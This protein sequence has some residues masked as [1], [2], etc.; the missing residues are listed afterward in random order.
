MTIDFEELIR[1]DR[2]DIKDNSIRSYL[3]SLRKMN[4]NQA[5]TDLKFLKNYKKIVEFL[6]KFALSTKRNYISSILVILKG[7]NKKSYDDV[8]EKYKKL[9]SELN[10]EYNKKIDSHEKSH[11]Q[12]ENWMPL[13]ELK[14]GL[15]IFKKEIKERE[16]KDKA[17]PS[18]KDMEIL[19]QYVVVALYTLHAPVRLNYANMKIINSAKDIKP[20]INYLLIT[21][22]NKKQFIFQEYKTSK[23]GGRKDIPVKKELNSV[24]NMWLKYNKSSYLLLDS[25]DEPMNPN[26]L[27]KYITKSF[28]FTGKKVT[29]NLLRHIYISSN[30]DLEAI[31]KSQQMSEDMMHSQ[32]MQEDYAKI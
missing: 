27:G 23:H 25:K 28:S 17:K 15:K 8:L 31:K 24:I 4:N 30:I 14:K 22:R 3:I 1:K 9:L 7:Y 32:A 20:N 29:L 12:K 6:D 5:L 19:Q 26:A 18:K 13:S 10:D 21:G 16:I 2:P 11:K